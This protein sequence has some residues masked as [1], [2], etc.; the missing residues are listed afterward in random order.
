[1]KLRILENL[2]QVSQIDKKDTAFIYL[3]AFSISPY[4]GDKISNYELIVQNM[5]NEAKK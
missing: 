1:M 4:L 2:F 3:T 5:A